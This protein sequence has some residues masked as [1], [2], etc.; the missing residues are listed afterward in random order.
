MHENILRRY[1]QALLAYELTKKK[2]TYLLYNDYKKKKK[3]KTDNFLEHSA[4]CKCSTF[5]LLDLL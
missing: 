1:F 5:W 2:S 3:P 4:V